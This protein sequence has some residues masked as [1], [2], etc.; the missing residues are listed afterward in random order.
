[1]SMKP[2]SIKPR[3]STRRVNL[4]INMNTIIYPEVEALRF[5]IEEQKK[6]IIILKAQNTR[7]REALLKIKIMADDPNSILYHVARE[8]LKE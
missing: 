8:A 3:T 6:E 2:S 4:N 5:L 1:M 7:Y